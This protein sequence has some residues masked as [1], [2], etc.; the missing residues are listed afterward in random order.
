MV[1]INDEG[2]R[3]SDAVRHQWWADGGRQVQL[4]LARRLAEHDAQGDRRLPP[5]ARARELLQLLFE[6]GLRPPLR[7][8]VSPVE[9]DRLYP[10]AV[11][12][13]PTGKVWVHSSTGDW[14]LAGADSLD[15][16][17]LAR[18]G[19]LTVQFVGH[20]PPPR[21]FTGRSRLRRST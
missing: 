15:A 3:A 16:D 10:G 13:D 2:S 9:L 20:P 8:V 1:D 5:A 4:E 21:P 14:Y 11:V 6:S 17:A 19:V 7:T 12:T 18:R